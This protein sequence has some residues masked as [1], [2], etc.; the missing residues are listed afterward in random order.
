MGGLQVQQDKMN[1]FYREANERFGETEPHGGAQSC[2][3]AM[4]VSILSVRK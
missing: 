2:A 4:Q 1:I 3:P